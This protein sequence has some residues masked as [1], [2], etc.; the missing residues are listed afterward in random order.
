[1]TVVELASVPGLPAL[2]RG[3]ATGDPVV[4]GWLPDR[5]SLAAIVARAAAVRSA[6]RARGA[7]SRGELEALATGRSVGIFTG[8]Q[9]GVFTGPLLTLVKALAAKKLAGAL[10]EAGLDATAGFWCASE[11]H[12][13]VEVTRFSVP[14]P[15]GP[16]ELGPDATLLAA[17]RR[18][19]G[20][21]P[22]EGLVDV[23]A[24]LKR[25]V[26]LVASASGAPADQEV[27]ETLVRFSSGATFREGFVKTLSWLLGDRAPLFV[28]AGN[29]A[30][31]PDLIPLAVRLVRERR[32][33]SRILEARASA[34]VAAGHPL[35]VT[36]EPAALP[37]FAI[38]DGGR[39]LLRAEGAG[40]SLKGYP[41][42]QGTWTEADV[43]SRFESG[44]WLPSFSALTRPLAAS[45]LYPIA[46][47]IL[48]P[49]EIAYWAQSYP[50]FS[51]FGIVPPVLVPRPMVA[52]VDAPTRRVLEKL[53]LG[54]SD[55]LRGAE[56][57]LKARGEA[58]ESGTLARIETLRSGCAE[59]LEALRS[60]LHEIEPALSKALD[61]TKENVAFALAK[62]SEKVSAAAG[63]ADGT[64][65]KQLARAQASLLPGGRLAERA[66]TPVPFLLWH[67]RDDLVEALERELQWDRPGIQVI[68]L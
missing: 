37:L 54:L 32:E 47:T 4:T 50:L 67:G 36:T 41:Q 60:G 48:G 5:P 52:L 28:D 46:A 38:V 11:D 23:S 43:V 40:F 6:F 1:M 19:V 21:L 24:V 64:F 66:F 3:L 44:A 61:T 29:P 65:A 17:N 27:L 55:L 33:V 26:E 51:H 68:D 62:L 16:V 15:E 45:V 30:D 7:G 63:R 57:I 42:Q 58:R 53:R 13:L 2:A 18:P 35:Q 39:Y 20:E 8:Q 59:T 34:L 31:K 22:I 12:D 56:P 49:A 14:G 9:V 10:S 25:A